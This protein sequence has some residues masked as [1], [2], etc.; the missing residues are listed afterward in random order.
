MHARA[1][2]ERKEP[3]RRRP[4]Q[5][6]VQAVQAQPVPVLRAGGMIISALLIGAY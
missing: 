4:S 5:I 2:T 1:R 6:V 3:H